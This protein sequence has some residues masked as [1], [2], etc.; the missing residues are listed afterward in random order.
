[1]VASLAPAR[2][3]EAIHWWICFVLRIFE[4]SCLYWRIFESEMCMVGV[5]SSE[6]MCCRMEFRSSFWKFGSCQSV[7]QK[8][9]KDFSI[10][11]RSV[12]GCIVPSLLVLLYSNM[13]GY[14]C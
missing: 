5:L 7:V 10:L 9:E 12:C 1:M 2:T 14:E 11:V 3:F 13:D 4:S 6:C 8:C